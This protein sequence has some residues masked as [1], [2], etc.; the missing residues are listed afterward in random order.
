MENKAFFTHIFLFYQ[1]HF[2]ESFHST[3]DSHYNPLLN[4]KTRNSNRPYIFHLY[5]PACDKNALC[6]SKVRIRL[7]SMLTTSFMSST[8]KLTLESNWIVVISLALFHS[9][10][11][12]GNFSRCFSLVLVVH[13][14]QSTCIIR[15]FQKVENYLVM[16]CEWVRK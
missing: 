11:R 13:W 14:Q 15:G 6:N 8:L 3:L 5:M 7:N 16:N 10:K 2:Y 1:V 4:W 12:M 9:H